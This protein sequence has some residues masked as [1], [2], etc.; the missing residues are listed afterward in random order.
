M[1][2]G[3]T[4]RGGRLIGATDRLSPRLIWTQ[5]WPLLI[6]RGFQQVVALVTLQA[7]HCT[8]I[9]RKTATV[10][11]T[12]SPQSPS[13]F[14]RP[15]YCHSRN[16]SDASRDTPR[17]MNQNPSMMVSARLF[18]DSINLSAPQKKR[19]SWSSLKTYWWQLLSAQHHF[20]WRLVYHHDCFDLESSFADS[21][22]QSGMI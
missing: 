6:I 1:P 12:M 16:E 22:D 9:F 8:S 3:C 20:R 14:F 2:R 18:T 5:V 4:W 11:S 15:I 10:L 19:T 21:A 17:L 13:V 7:L